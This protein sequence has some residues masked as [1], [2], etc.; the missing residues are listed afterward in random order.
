[1]TI[2]YTVYTFC[3]VIDHVFHYIKY[4]ISICLCV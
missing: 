4:D 2:V 3:H 1:V